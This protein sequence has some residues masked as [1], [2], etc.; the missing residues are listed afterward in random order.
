MVMMDAATFC[1]LRTGKY[2]T[3]KTWFTPDEDMRW[4]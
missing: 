2:G 4:R 1:C 3:I